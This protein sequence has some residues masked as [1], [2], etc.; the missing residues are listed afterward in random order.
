MIKPNGFMNEQGTY[1]KGFRDAIDPN[2]PI[3]SKFI[4]I[5]ILK[6]LKSYAMT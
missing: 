2:F 5:N 1:I 6:E 4:F 3:S